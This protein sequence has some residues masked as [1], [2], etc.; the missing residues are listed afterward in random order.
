MKST[1]QLPCA[2]PAGRTVRAPEQ[3]ILKQRS[4]RAHG[5]Q[6][7]EENRVQEAKRGKVLR[8]VSGMKS[9]KSPPLGDDKITARFGSV[10]GR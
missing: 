4:H 10:L 7:P 2:V 6:R 9:Y 3:T 1:D 8:A 5:Q